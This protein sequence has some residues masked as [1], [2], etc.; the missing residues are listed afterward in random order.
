ME[1]KRQEHHHQQAH[2]HQQRHLHLPA[3]QQRH[4]HLPVLQQRVQ[5]VHQH[6]PV[7]R[8]QLAHLQQRPIPQ[9]QVFFKLFF[10]YCFRPRVY[11]FRI[12]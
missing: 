6:L 4:P 7:R 2:R 10:K 1:P 12:S 9:E 11:I 5:R 8:H 3:L